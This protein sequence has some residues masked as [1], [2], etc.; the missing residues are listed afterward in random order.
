ML[1]DDELEARD[2]LLR[3]LHKQ[4]EQTARLD[5]RRFCLLNGTTASL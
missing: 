4:L 5:Q 1:G 2:I 3:E